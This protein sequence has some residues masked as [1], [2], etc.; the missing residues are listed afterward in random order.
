MTARRPGTITSR[1][2]DDHS[3]DDQKTNRER[4]HHDQGTTTSLLHDDH[5]IRRPL[6]GGGEGS[7]GE[8]RAG[9]GDGRVCVLRVGMGWGRGGLVLGRG[10]F[11]WGG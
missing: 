4:P 7:G 3:T 1:V 10:G 6:E 5:A 11:W 8:D 9:V 2:K